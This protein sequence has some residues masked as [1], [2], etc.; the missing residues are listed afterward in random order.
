MTENLYVQGHLQFWDELKRRNPGLSI[1]SCASGGRRNDL[2]TMR[3]AVPLLRSDFQWPDSQKNVYEG[4]QGHTYGLSSWLPF[5]GSGVYGCDPYSFRSFYMPSF[6]MGRLTP[7]NKAAQRQAYSECAQI[8]PLML[9]GDYY[10]LTP[11]SVHEDA[12]IAWQFDRPETGEGCVQAFRRAKCQVSAIKLRLLG[13]EDSKTYEVQDFDKTNKMLFLGGE[14]KRDG[15]PVELE[16][17]SAAVFRYHL[18]QK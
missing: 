8:S 4:N 7:E 10:P 1:D 2:E 18:I 6:G 17:R 13:L 5:Q 15:L 11:Y 12:W 3:R 16:A 9:F 14:L